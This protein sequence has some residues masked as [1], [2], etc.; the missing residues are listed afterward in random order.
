MNEELFD[1]GTP[2]LYLFDMDYTLIQNDCDISWKKFLVKKGL[3]SPDA[4]NR[5]EIYYRLYCQNELDEKE[6]LTFQL[7]EFRGQPVKVIEELAEEHFHEIVKPLTYPYWIDF[8]KGLTEKGYPSAIVTATNSVV[9][10]PTA[11]Y[12]GIEKLIS[13]IP[14]I[15]NGRFTGNISGE[16]CYREGKINA[17]MPYLE[18]LKIPLAKTAYF[19]DSLSDLP[20]LSE[21]GY[22]VTVNPNA[23]LKEKIKIYNWKT[24]KL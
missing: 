19:G 4:I 22:P 20:L 23:Q 1:S 15:K 3:A 11:E 21:V 24:I 13:T 8:I 9:A 6:F 10:A 7:K 12:L 18:E 14:E 5:A 2:E 16:Y 17:V